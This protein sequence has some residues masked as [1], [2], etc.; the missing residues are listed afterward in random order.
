VLVSFQAVG[1]TDF[2]TAVS[3]DCRALMP[4]YRVHYDLRIL[5]ISIELEF[6]IRSALRASSPLFLFSY[7][8][9][10]LS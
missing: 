7:P 6:Y 4:C 2:S 9:Y 8:L 10:L 5:L 1:E 3:G